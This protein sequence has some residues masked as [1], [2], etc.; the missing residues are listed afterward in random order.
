MQNFSDL[1]SITRVTFSNWGLN[2]QEVG[3][4]CIFNGP[5]IKN[6]DG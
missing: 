2:E 1:Q 5:Y 4:L 3:K 6:S